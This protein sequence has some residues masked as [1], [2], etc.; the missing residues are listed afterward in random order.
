M[1]WSELIIAGLL[2]IVGVIGVKKVAEKDNFINNVILIAGFLTSF[3]F[4]SRAIAVIPLS[5][6]YAVWTGI[7]T[8]G[9]AIVGM[10]FFREAK[11]WIRL[12]CIMGVIGAVVS[13]KLVG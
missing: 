13:L 12:L 3:F 7:G 10:L 9:A 4:L 11:S 5:T 8:V 2:E 1:E 6:A